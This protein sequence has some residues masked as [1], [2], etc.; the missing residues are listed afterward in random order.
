MK[1]VGQW[2]EQHQV[3]SFVAITGALAFAISLPGIFMFATEQP[4]NHIVQGSFLRFFFVFAKDWP[5]NYIIQY[6]FVR[7]LIFSPALAGLIVTRITA[8][9]EPHGSIWMRATA[10]L[11]S[12]VLAVAVTFLFI[13]HTGTSWTI[14]PYPSTSLTII[15]T[16]LGALFPAFIISAAFSRRPDT[17]RFLSTLVKPRGRYYWYLA[18][19]FAFPVFSALGSAVTRSFAENPSS[20]VGD[21]SSDAVSRTVATFLYALF[22]TGGFG[23]EAGWRGFALPRLQARYCPL[24]ACLVIWFLHMIWELPGDVVFSDNPWPAMGRLVWMPCWSVL[25]VWIYN[26]TD[27]SILAP[28][29]LHASISATTSLNAALL[30]TDAATVLLFG[31][32]GFAVVNDRM[33]KSLP[34]SS[35]AVQ[36]IAR[37]P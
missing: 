36:G 37:T 29:L 25:L 22:F 26:R 10:F 12:W 9:Q 30:H 7:V 15:N 31:L 3:T 27:G 33:W 24:V 23:Q 6:C 16:A 4:A 11:V 8:K 13:S 1:T 18:A 35:L 19:L 20:P 14:I 21:L 34:A 17:R 28:T 32:A 2:V 5:A